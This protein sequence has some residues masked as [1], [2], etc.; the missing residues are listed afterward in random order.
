MNESSPICCTKELVE[1]DRKSKFQ[2]QPENVVVAV[3]HLLMPRVY[4]G[5]NAAEPRLKTRHRRRC[6]IT[7]RT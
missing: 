2:R 1:W 7:V 4:L 3:D 5:V 6:S